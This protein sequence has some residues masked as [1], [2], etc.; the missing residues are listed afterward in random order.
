MYTTHKKKVNSGI[1][2]KIHAD[3]HLTLKE[4]I[5]NEINLKKPKNK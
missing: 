1:K 3:K 2:G 4:M 5:I